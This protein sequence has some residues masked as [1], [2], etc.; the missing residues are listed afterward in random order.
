MSSALLAGMT[1]VRKFT[2][3]RAWQACVTYKR[4]VYRV[5]I[6]SPL[7]QDWSRRGQ[8]ESSVTAPPS[9]VAEGYGRFNPLDFARFLVMARASLMESQ[10]HLID[11][12]DKGYISEEARLALDALAVEALQ[13]VTGLMEYL[14]SPEALRNARR[15]RERRM[16]TRDARRNGR[17]DEP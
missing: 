5:L 6:G 14:Q 10:N 12:V 7:A 3:L 11:A 2:D 1:G 8:L 13:E 9:H 15:A 4:A 16:A 17:R